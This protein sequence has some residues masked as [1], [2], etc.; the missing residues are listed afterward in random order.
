[1]S[2]MRPGGGSR[3]C[4]L[5]NR[6]RGTLA[7]GQGPSPSRGSDPLCSSKDPSPI[8]YLLLQVGPEL[9]MQRCGRCQVG[10]P[11]PGRV[12]VLGGQARGVPKSHHPQSPPVTYEEC[13]PGLD[14]VLA[15]VQ[16]AE[17]LCEVDAELLLA[18]GHLAGGQHA[19][20][21]LRPGGRALQR[22]W[23]GSCLAFPAAAQCPPAPGPSPGRPRG[24][25]G[26]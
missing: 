21:T 18:A 15:A 26:R 20:H 6:W 19:C 12:R 16:A 4:N 23:T 14:V 7:T 8:T 11:G 9:Q 25:G 3:G 22:P 1:M 10:G 13:C 17:G 2:G 5:R 24:S